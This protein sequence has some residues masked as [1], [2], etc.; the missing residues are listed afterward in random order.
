M[1]DFDEGGGGAPMSPAQ[2]LQVAQRRAT[3]LTEPAVEDVESGGGES[4]TIENPVAGRNGAGSGGGMELA[5]APAP[6]PGALLRQKPGDTS[7]AVSMMAWMSAMIENQHKDIADLQSKAS[8]APAAGAAM[9]SGWATPGS[10]AH[11][12]VSAD[13][14]AKSREELIEFIHQNP[15][16]REAVS[17]DP[18]EK[19][20]FVE[21]IAGRLER[22]FYYKDSMIVK[23]GADATE[24]YFIYAGMAE[25]YL[26]HPD[27]AEESKIPPVARL[28]K[29]TFF[30]EAALLSEERTPRNAWIRANCDMEV[31]C[32][33]ADDLKHSLKEH[34]VMESMF[35]AEKHRRELQRKEHLERFETGGGNFRRGFKVRLRTLGT[36]EK[37]ASMVTS[38]L[39]EAFE[40]V[41]EVF[42][43][44]AV[45]ALLL[46]KVEALENVRDQLAAKGITEAHGHGKHHG[47]PM[48]EAEQKKTIYQ[49]C[50]LALI[51]FSLCFIPF[52]SVQ[53]HSEEMLLATSATHPAMLHLN[54]YSACE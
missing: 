32:L 10:G 18:E 9:P 12:V 16:F 22:R 34:P 35:N 8:S 53:H 6:S 5:M 43:R 48:T 38:E 41:P 15:V 33:S 2:L 54:Y 30:G 51:F 13:D 50:L 27:A 44:S 14:Q 11:D 21:E 26:D 37:L 42:P 31:Y 29:G 46:D 45:E 17:I 7:D 39:E 19:E 3:A 24:M 23:K 49:M 25:V 4:E 36:K 28:K 20:N 47:K 40:T 52:V 1:T